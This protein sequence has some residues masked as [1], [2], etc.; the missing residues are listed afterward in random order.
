MPDNKTINIENGVEQTKK[1]ADPAFPIQ[2]FYHPDVQYE[3]CPGITKREYFAAAALTGLL[4]GSKHAVDSKDFA[5]SSFEIADA[6]I[7]E[8]EKP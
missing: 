6:M 7:E 5:I 4:A 8:S 1:N 2:F 3:S